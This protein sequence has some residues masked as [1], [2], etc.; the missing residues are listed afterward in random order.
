MEQDVVLRSALVVV[1]DNVLS[2]R[3]TLCAVLQLL[4][5]AGISAKDVSIMVVAKFLVHRS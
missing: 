5:K 3:E 2:I 4:D 1:V